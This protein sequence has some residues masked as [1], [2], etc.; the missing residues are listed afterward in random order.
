VLTRPSRNIP[1]PQAA[2]RDMAAT[3]LN[4]PHGPAGRSRRRRAFI[5][6]PP[7]SAMV[8]GSALMLDGGWSAGK[9][10]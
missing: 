8:T 2:Y 4:G 3:Q 1:D 9:I 10:K 6:P 5:L 7:K